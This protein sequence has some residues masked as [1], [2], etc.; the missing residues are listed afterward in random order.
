MRRCVYLKRRVGRKPDEH[1]RADEGAHRIQIHILLAH[2]HPVGP[3]SGGNVGTIVDDEQRPVLLAYGPRRA[4]GPQE[5]LAIELLLAQLHDLDTSGDC[6][7]EHLLELAS[8][9]G[10]VAYE[11]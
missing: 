2:V 5:L 8:P 11:I 1:L 4:C 3:H 9:G 6:A 7:R 10:A